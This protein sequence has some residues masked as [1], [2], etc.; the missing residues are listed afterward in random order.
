MEETGNHLLL[1]ESRPPREIQ[2]ID[3]VE[4]VVFAVF[5]QARD[6]IGHRRVGGLFQYGKLGLDVAHVGNLDGIAGAFQQ[7]LLSE[8]VMRNIG[9]RSGCVVTTP[10]GITGS[11]VEQLDPE[12]AD[13]LGQRQRRFHQ[14]EMRADAD[15][16]ADAE[17]QIGEAIGR[18]RPA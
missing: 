17:R 8:R 7:C 12:R 6:R 11:C 4:L 14:R 5:D 13:H 18:R 3:A 16:R 1:V 15:P 9:E 2:H 10:I